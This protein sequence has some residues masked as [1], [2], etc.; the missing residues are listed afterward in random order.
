VNDFEPAVTESAQSIGVTA[1]LLAVMMI[2]SLS[3]RTTGQALLRKKID[4]VAKV[5][6]NAELGI[7]FPLLL[8]APYVV[9]ATF[10]S[11]VLS[12]AKGTRVFSAFCLRL[13][14]GYVSVLILR[15]L[16]GLIKKFLRPFSGLAGTP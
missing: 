10:R 5:F 14:A 15:L 8:A 2:V 7:T 9:T 6:G 4:G 16:P 3:P 13:R 12:A 11:V 1:I